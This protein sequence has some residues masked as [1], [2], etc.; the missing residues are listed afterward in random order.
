MFWDIPYNLSEGPRTHEEDIQSRDI[1]K[2]LYTTI[3]VCLRGFTT[4]VQVYERLYPDG[5]T[6]FFSKCPGANLL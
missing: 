5:L 3:V 1:S 4:T 2:G 6:G